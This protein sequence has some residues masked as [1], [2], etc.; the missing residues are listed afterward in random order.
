MVLLP[1]R[2]LP[3][4]WASAPG[5]ISSINLAG[6]RDP[7]TLHWPLAAGPSHHSASTATAPRGP[8]SP[9]T[10][11]VAITVSG[12]PPSPGGSAG[13]P[14]P[15]LALLHPSTL[16][17]HSEIVLVGVS[18]RDHRRQGRASGGFV[19]TSTAFEPVGTEA[20]AVSPDFVRQQPNVPQ[21]CQKGFKGKTHYSNF[22]THNSSVPL[23]HCL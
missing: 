22:P 10:S 14:K 7:G 13:S 12:L 8:C 11:S 19:E 3:A 5:R 21:R 17:N 2:D 16:R 6:I 23:H 1:G 20:R 9:G 4:T 18:P 15:L